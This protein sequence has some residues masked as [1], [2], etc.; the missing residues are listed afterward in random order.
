MLKIISA[1]SGFF[2]SDF[3]MLAS[4]SCS[5]TEAGMLLVSMQLFVLSHLRPLVKLDLRIWA[6]TVCVPQTGLGHHFGPEWLRRDSCPNWGRPWKKTWWNCPCWRRSPVSKLWLSSRSPFCRPTKT[7]WT[8]KP[9]CTS[10]RPWNCPG[11]KSLPTLEKLRSSR[12]VQTASGSS[13]GSS[14]TVPAETAVPKSLN[15][16]FSGTGTSCPGRGC[17]TALY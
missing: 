1:V 2:K 16:G 7:G 10:F 15:R 14:S 6:N 13:C 11:R 3:F 8:A 12:S 17:S 4:F 5:L 9:S